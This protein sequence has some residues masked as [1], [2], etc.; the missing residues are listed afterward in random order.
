MSG[1]YFV[2]E[3]QPSHGNGTTSQG[4]NQEGNAG[5]HQSIET[6]KVAAMNEENHEKAPPTKPSSISASYQEFSM[7]VSSKYAHRNLTW[8]EETRLTNYT[9]FQNN[10][11][12]KFALI[13]R[14]GQPKNDQLEFHEGRILLSLLTSMKRLCLIRRYYLL[15]KCATNH[16]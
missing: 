3:G 8:E 5:T 12:N 10:T 7:K 16:P 11:D 13:V 6:T 9:Q 14:I 4:N 1:N 15:N 2:K